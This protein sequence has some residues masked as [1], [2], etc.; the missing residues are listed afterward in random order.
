MNPWPHAFT[1]VRR[2]AGQ[3]DRAAAKRAQNAGVL[4]RRQPSR[5]GRMTSSDSAPEGMKPRP[6]VDRLP[7]YAAGKPPAD[8]EGLTNYKL[9]SNENPLPPIPAVL[10][11][12]AEQTD[13]NRYP[14][15]LSTKLRAA[16]SEFLG[17]PAEDIV[18]GQG[19][20]GALNQILA[21]F[22]G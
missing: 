11:A 8:I 9:S 12:I 20:L 19:S 10:Q 17:V 14:D 4:A 6:V 3:E 13:I 22:A 16:L 1:C 18:T 5:L 2:T 15:P 21:T 7:R